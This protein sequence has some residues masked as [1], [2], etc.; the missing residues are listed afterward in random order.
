MNQQEIIAALHEL[1]SK[2]SD[3]SE[4]RETR[5]AQDQR[6]LY[7]A[8]RNTFDTWEQ[9]LIVALSKA[10]EG[11]ARARP[12]AATQSTTLQEAPESRE[13]SAAANHSLYALSAAGYLSALTLSR[14]PETGAGQW[15]YLPDGPERAAW[16]ERVYMGD[17]DDG[18][19]FALAADGTGSSLHRPHFA[20]WSVD[21]RPARY[22][23]HVLRAQD[24]PVVGM[25]PRRYLRLA[26]RVYAV[27]SD[28]QIKASDTEEYAK[29]LSNEVIDVILPRGEARAYTMFAGRDDADI[30]IASSGG[31]AIVFKASEL[32]SQGLRA[33]GVRGINLDDG[34]HVVGAFEVEE[35]EVILVTEQGYV[36]RMPLSEFRPQGRGGAGLQTCRLGDGDRVVSMVQG[37]INDDLLLIDT[38]GQYLRIPVWKIPQMTRASRGDQLAAPTPEQQIL[39]ACVVPAGQ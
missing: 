36:K 19:F 17:A 31:K 1:A 4:L 5:V 34:H 7:H 18:T 33:Q 37:S 16:P 24:E 28:G 2:V 3:P 15:A 6:D 12:S 38:D 39:D 21:A 27:A 29:R 11:S 22:V 35:D 10:L 8:S 32:R 25:F 14:L 9:T 30:F 23:D 20:D 13:I 26:Q